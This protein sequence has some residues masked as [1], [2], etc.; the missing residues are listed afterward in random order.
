MVGGKR[1]GHFL[2]ILHSNFAEGATKP[3]KIQTLWYLYQSIENQKS[4][5]LIVYS[6]IEVTTTLQK[7]KKT[8][9]SPILAVIV[10]SFHC[11]GV[12]QAK[13]VMCHVHKLYLVCNFIDFTSA[14]ASYATWV[15]SVLQNLDR[16]GYWHP[17][18]IWSAKI[19]YSPSS[20]S[21]Y[22]SCYWY[23][24][25]GNATRVAFLV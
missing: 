11:A 10:R 15:A 6:T 14:T 21:S 7:L 4:Y 25:T 17:I 12:F 24:F 22:V 8:L 5:K 3:R 16:P 9:S 2:S 13:T 20:V 19:R 1:H 18:K 23:P